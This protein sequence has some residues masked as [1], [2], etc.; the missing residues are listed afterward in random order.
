[1]S[2]VFVTGATGYIGSHVCKALKQAGYKV[3]GLDRVPRDHTIKYMDRFIEADYHSPVCFDAMAYE[4]PDAVIHLAGTSLVGPSMADPAEYY[5][6]N[7]AKTAA[8]LDTVRWLEHMPVVVF[9]SSAAVYGNPD[10]KVIYEHTPYSP[11]SPYG[12]SKTMIEIM[13]TDFNR[14]YGMKSASLRYFN[15]CGADPDSELGQE[16]GATHIIARLLE[17]VRDSTEFT[18]YGDGTHVRDYVH[19]TDLATAHV[20]AVQYLM[21]N[22]Q[23]CI[24]LNLGT[25]TGASNQEIIDLVAQ[26]IGPVQLTKTPAR[27]GD[28]AQLVAG[29]LMA[30]TTLGW[31]PDHSD[32]NTII[33]SAWKWYN[34]LPHVIDNSSK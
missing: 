10:A 25:G 11:L 3:V 15:A 27:P 33:E 26:L 21:S 32:L 8:F 4:K 12:T 5:V 28:P 6:N 22:M 24:A 7:V 30:K 20:M 19:V 16:P 1:M 18:L 31:S 13:L 14:A 2:T 29:N 23:E 34:N 9:S 17:S